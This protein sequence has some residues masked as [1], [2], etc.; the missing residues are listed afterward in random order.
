MEKDRELLFGVLAVQLK[1]I[2]PQ[3]LMEAAAVWAARQERSLAEILVEQG[4]LNE[5]KQKLISSLLEL[6]VKEH[7][8][9]AKASLQSFGGDRAVY[10]SFAGSIVVDKDRLK[11]ASAA[12]EKPSKAPEDLEDTQHLSLEH[13]GRYSFKGEYSRGGIG[14]IMIAV[15]EHIGREIAVKELLPE[16]GPDGTPLS[17]SPVRKT[18]AATARFLREARITGQLEHPSIVPVYELGRR[19]DG[20]IYYTMKLVRGKTLSEKMA[21]AKSLKERLALLPDFLEL[22][23]AIAY[24]HSRG[25]IHRDLKP[26]NVMIGEFGETV[27]IDWGLAKVKGKEDIRAKDIERDARLMKEPGIGETV[28]GKPI[29]TPSYMSPEQADGK[30]EEIDEKSD[31]YGLGAVLYEILT[32]HPPFEGVNAYEVMGRVLK[33]EPKRI[34]DW[35]KEAPAELASIAEKCLAKDKPQRYASA[36]ILAEDI[37]SYLSGGMVS[38][39]NYSLALIAR[40]W[41]AKNAAMLL[42][43]GTA[44]VILLAFGAWSFLN[45]REQRDTAIE[46]LAESYILKGKIAEAGGAWSN[47]RVYYAKSLSIIDSPLAR[48]LLDYAAITP[49]VELN[50]AQTWLTPADY[51]FASKDGRVWASACNCDSRETFQPRDS[52]EQ[53]GCVALLDTSAGKLLKLLKPE[54]AE[55]SMVLSPEGEKIAVLD[56][57]GRIE[58]WDIGAEKIWRSF[59]NPEKHC[60][61]MALSGHGQKLASVSAE[62]KVWPER[63][64]YYV[65]TV[66]DTASGAPVIS[67]KSKDIILALEF[68]PDGKKLAAGG[69][70]RIIR[71]WDADSGRLMRE[72]KGHNFIIRKLVFSPDGQK[73]ASAAPEKTARLWEV[74]TGKLLGLLEGHTQE[75]MDIIFSPDGKTLAS[76]SRDG[77]LKLW[78]A[79]SGALLNSL[80]GHAD[81][82]QTIAFSRNG[83]LLAS[84]GWRSS[85]KLW[86]VS[87]GKLLT[88]L[89][90]R[91]PADLL[92]FSPDE[93]ALLSTRSHDNIRLW[94]I[95]RKPLVSFL[96]NS[97]DAT[98]RIITL[99]NQIRFY[100]S[101]RIVALDNQVNLRLFSAAR[102]DT[103]EI[104]DLKSGRTERKFFKAPNQK[105]IAFSTDGF[106]VAFVNRE[107]REIAAWDIHSGEFSKILSGDSVETSGVSHLV[108]SPDDKK[109]AWFGKSAIIQTLD[110]ESKKL[111]RLEPGQDAIYKICFSPDSK[112]LASTDGGKTVK[113][114]DTRTGKLA[115]TMD[116]DT[117]GVSFLA[118]SPDGQKLAIGGQGLVRLRD[119][120]TGHLLKDFRNSSEWVDGIVFSPDGKKLAAGS[121]ECR[122]ELWDLASGELKKS[123]QEDQAYFKM[124]KFSPEGKILAV[125]F[126]TAT[127]NQIKLWNADSGELIKTFQGCDLEFSPDGSVLAVALD[128][129]L[130]LW[131]FTP[132]IMRGKPEKLL[133]QAEKETGLKV[134]GMSLYPWN[135]E[136]AAVSENPLQESY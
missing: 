95:A 92:C 11:P 22:C 46:K 94:N 29:G 115:G 99:D 84:S 10:E 60:F 114:W 67:F 85:I 91:G 107:N 45:I 32:G 134:K 123:F 8:G 113:L 57:S 81:G 88:Y 129:E 14:R 79:E 21:E 24:A 109:I 68:S 72:L 2:S 126:E 112:I 3:K 7:G 37:T 12:A 23:Q 122:V 98:P 78:D 62:S 118:F 36:N 108:F 50:L 52:K 17:D 106:R 4:L 71:V 54:D 87:S 117:E 130:L 131:C 53:K 6:Q 51:A 116:G 111:L 132:E 59:A 121:R 83:K 69:R 135:P 70:D 49:Q 33:E 102:G 86:N 120:A 42:T 25:V 43:A 40:R 97:K 26:Q 101:P 82:A 119:A 56:K 77:T 44:L 15:D 66:W 75:I 39:Y 105:F 1:L 16:K 58:L 55:G 74:G 103:V 89:E 93:K 48:Y 47:A 76:S 35:E 9:D 31:L 110:L 13:P 90:G 27:V 124:L 34:Q 28:Q 30:I 20:S 18:G 100:E 64:R 127:P 136:T 19:T 63:P 133:E 125:V 41:M 61:Y 65:L 38:A 5:E 104:D 73:L 80:E 96:P 128:N